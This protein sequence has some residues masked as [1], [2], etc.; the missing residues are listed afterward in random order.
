MKKYLVALL[1]AAIVLV[2]PAGSAL[3]AFDVNMGELLAPLSGGISPGSTGSG[4]IPTFV[5]TAVQRDQWVEI[6][7]DN[8]PAHDHFVVTMGPMGTRGVGGIV[9]STTYSDVGGRFVMKYPIPA[10]LHGSHQIAIRLESPTSHYFAYNWFYNSNANVPGSTPGP[11]GYSGYPTFDISGVVQGDSVTISPHNFPPNDTFW[12]RMNWIGTQGIAGAVVEEIT[13]DANGNLPKTT[14]D[15]PD[16]LQNAHQV[17]IR[18]ESPYTGYY[19]YNWFYNN[20]YPASS[21]AATQTAAANQGAAY[22]LPPGYVGHPTVAITAV[23]R[24]QTVSIRTHNLTPND[25]YVVT[26]GLMGT[27]G[28]SGYYVTEFNSGTDSVQDLTFNIPAQLAGLHQI[29]IR[30]ESPISGFYAYNWFYNN[31]YPG[32]DPAPPPP[33]PGYVGHPWMYIAAVDKDDT[34]TITAH[35]FP[36]NDTFWVRMNWIGTQG[37]AGT[38]VE[39]VTTNAN[40][41]LSDLTYAIPDFL[42]GTYQIAIRIE[43]PY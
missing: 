10:A 31:T 33:G 37:I 14:F 27:R 17:A 42:N 13:T 3:V 38:V 34:V 25:K 9:V 39:T 2:L 8:F 23:E 29:S 43:S 22:V 6:Q 11:V 1:M 19:A 5:I 28:V 7:T 16:F 40:G 41:T 18:L 36:P 12:V 26:M 30:I 20:T 4:I 24:D 32:T 15:I 21:S 35:N